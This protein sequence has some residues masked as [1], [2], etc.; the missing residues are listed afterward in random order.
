MLAQNYIGFTKECLTFENAWSEMLASTC[1][2]AYDLISIA[3]NSLVMST[4]GSPDSRVNLNIELTEESWAEIIKFI[5][6]AI[7]YQLLVSHCCTMTSR[8]D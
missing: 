8:N 3:H 6:I 1:I 2:I 5:R 7:R 4:V